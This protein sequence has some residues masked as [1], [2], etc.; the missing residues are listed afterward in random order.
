MKKRIIN[1]E[2]PILIEDI[3]KFE[4]DNDI[5]FPENLKNLYLKYNG[6][7]IEISDSNFYDFASLK[8]GEFRLEEL[9]NDLQIEENV[10]PENF[11]PF[12]T[13]GVGH[14]IT[15]KISDSIYNEIYLFRYDELNPKKI[16]NSLEEFLGVN[17]IEEL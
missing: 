4:K 11:I 1:S 12:A 2:I 9:L 13:T 17:S 3:E 6:G 7:E 15:I 10:I 14:I 5:I 8:Y 16:S